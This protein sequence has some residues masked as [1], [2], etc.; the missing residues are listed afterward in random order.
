MATEANDRILESP[1]LDSLFQD[2]PTDRRVLIRLLWP[3]I[4]ACLDR[5]H[6]IQQVH[7]RLQLDGVTVSYASLCRYVAKLRGADRGVERAPTADAATAGKGSGPRL[8]RPGPIKDPLEN[9][10]RLTEERRPGFQ[11]RGTL[12]EKDLYGE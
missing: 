8:Q 6:T 3:K 2:C 10:R 4:R 1:H 9:V 12:S 11:Y 7:E 5:G